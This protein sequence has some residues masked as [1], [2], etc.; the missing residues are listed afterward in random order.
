[1]MVLRPPRKIVASLALCATFASTALCGFAA[2]GDP[3]G[4]DTSPAA[5]STPSGDSTSSTS[6]SGVASGVPASAPPPAS[7]APVTPRATEAH[8]VKPG[9]AAS[10]GAA[11]AQPKKPATLTLTGRIEELCKGNSATLPLKW[12]KMEPIRDPSLD[13]KPLVGKATATPPLAAR[14]QTSYPMDFRGTWSGSLTIYQRTY[15]PIRWQ[16]DKEKADKEYK[17]LAPGRTGQVSI[18]FYQKPNG[19]V[20]MEPCQVVFQTTQT[21]AEATRTMNQQFGGMGQ[22]GL[23]PQQ[24]AMFAN[25]QV[26]EIYALHL[27]DLH[28]GIGVTGNQLNSTLLKND[29]KQL[30]SDV[31]EQNVIT[32]DSDRNPRTGVVNLGFSESVLRFTRV[33]SNQ[34]YLQA[35]TVNYRNDGK[36]TDKVILYGTLNRS[37]GA[38]PAGLPQFP[39]MP[40]FG[41]LGG[42]GGNM[43]DAARQLQQMMQQM[44]R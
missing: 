39:G 29:I 18:A 9:S 43:M 33:S 40:S 4:A 21:M 31:I 5:T 3:T 34:L 14:T 7:P 24:A 13:P 26:P 32:R 20:F 11:T 16:M 42:G 28:A 36:F 44:Q 37:N 38:A 35:A 27:G 6:E 15:D 25:M 1:M 22:M 12:K 19:G 2:D 23:S 17:L 41:G 30:R 8:P 10:P